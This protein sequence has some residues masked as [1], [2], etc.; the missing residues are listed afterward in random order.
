[1]KTH[2]P[3][4]R[5]ALAAL[6]FAIPALVAQNKDISPDDR[7][8][9][10]P[11]NSPA[12]EPTPAARHAQSARVLLGQDL[13]NAQGDGLGEVK[14]LLIDREDG[15]IAFAVIETGGFLGVGEETRAVPF[16]A[17]RRAADGSRNLVLEIERDR[18][19]Q[20]PALDTDDPSALTDRN[21]ARGVIAFYRD[22][23]NRDVPGID[24]AS[25]ERL[26]PVSEIIG[27]TVLHENEEIGSIDDVIV[28][29]DSRRA[30]AL[31]DPEDEITDN[32]GRLLVN[33]AQLEPASDDRLSTTLTPE[34]IATAQPSDDRWWTLADGAAYWWSGYGGFGGA[35]HVMP[36]DD[37]RINAA[38]A[39]G[40]HEGRPSVDVIRG[41]LRS[42][43]ALSERARLATVEE[44]GNRLILE[45]LVDSH[46]ARNEVGRLV[47]E[48]ADGW[49]VV[50]RLEVR[51]AAE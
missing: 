4:A 20:A 5:P 11:E 6:F 12:T 28:H 15:K 31:F 25:R 41:R 19:S 36:T 37:H 10:P 47:S 51:T 22:A 18:W 8:P 40:H 23:L 3:F 9:V 45:G 50:N 46:A 38:I 29:F 2:L 30:S 1:M 35:A 44:D 48:V 33:F 13:E 14:D 43:P 16:S 26:L 32:D 21:V 24:S 17:L 42:D 39:A 7:T 34:Q 49:E 27:R